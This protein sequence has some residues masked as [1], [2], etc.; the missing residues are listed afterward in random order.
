MTRGAPTYVSSGRI[1]PPDLAVGTNQWLCECV[2]NGWSPMGSVK[3]PCSRS[4]C[5]VG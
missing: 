3:G 2:D 1:G 4:P 5:V